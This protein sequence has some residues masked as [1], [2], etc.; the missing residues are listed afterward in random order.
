[1]TNCGLTSMSSKRTRK[2][3]STSFPRRGHVYAIDFDPARGR[4]IKKKRPAVIVSNNQMNEKGKTV[5]AM[6]IT[7]G[8]YA[9]YFRIPIEP[10]EGGLPKKSVIATEQIRALDKNR[11]GPLLGKLNLET[12]LQVEQSIRDHF[13]LPEGNILP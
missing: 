5:L 8:K 7:S 11:I 3:R 1:M 4:E 12:M 13:G 2:I 10:P 9:Y 6:P